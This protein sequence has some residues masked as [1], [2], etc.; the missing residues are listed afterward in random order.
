MTEQMKEPMVRT[1]LLHFPD[2]EIQGWLTAHE[3][4]VGTSVPFNGDEWIVTEIRPASDG[5]L[6]VTVR[7]SDRLRKARAQALER[8]R[9]VWNLPRPEVEPVGPVR[10]VW[11]A[12]EAEVVAHTLPTD[13]PTAA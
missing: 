11:P 5:A 10:E 3:F 8:D 4:T 2:G 13:E 9:E 1:V 6:Y 7:E 12:R